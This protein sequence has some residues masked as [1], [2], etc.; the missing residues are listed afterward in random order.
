MED[1]KAQNK[2]L[3]LGK[4]LV[5]ELELDPGVDTLAK[6]M[7]H[8]VAEMMFSAENLSGD[9]KTKA[10]EKCCDVILKL[11]EHRRSI[12]RN[13]PFLQDFESLLETLDRLNPDKNAPFFFP[14]QLIFEL[15]EEI[16]QG[17]TN[18][19]D[20]EP[21]VTEDENSNP[22]NL[23]DLSLRVDKIARSLIADLLKKAVSGFRLSSEREDLIRISIEAIAY[24]ESRII[25]KFLDYGNRF[26]SQK[27]K[28]DK[29]QE[30]I[31]EINNKLNQLENLNSF[32]ESLSSIY[33]KE[34]L[35]LEK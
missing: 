30:R 24:P 19:S 20:N 16:E 3:T 28:T 7:A 13:K 25:K 9:E 35:E 12:P 6:W 4:A 15:E 32:I 33:K 22:R 5:K 31:L 2:I 27:E 14:P 29:T 11:W 34:L 10:E 26:E 21:D 23:L 8:Y 1:S 18:E 17:L